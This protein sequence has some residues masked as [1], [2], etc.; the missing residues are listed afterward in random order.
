MGKNIE[1]INA[2]IDSGSLLWCSILLHTSAARLPSDPK[3]LL[4][5]AINDAFFNFGCSVHNF[6]TFLKRAFDE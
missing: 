2:S 5:Q 3:E 1:A 4:L 6:A